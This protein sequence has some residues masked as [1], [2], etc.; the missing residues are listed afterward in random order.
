M[1]FERGECTGMSCNWKAWNPKILP[2][3]VCLERQRWLLK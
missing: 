3:P 1:R 2:P